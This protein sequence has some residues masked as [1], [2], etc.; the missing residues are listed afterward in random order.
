MKGNGKGWK[1][2]EIKGNEMEEDQ[3]KWKEINTE[4]NETDSNSN[5]INAKNKELD[6][7]RKVI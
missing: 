6:A 1:W 5:A 7:Q 2:T 3:R 4:S